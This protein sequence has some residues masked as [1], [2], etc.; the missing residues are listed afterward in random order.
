VSGGPARWARRTGGAV[1]G[2]ERS[3]SRPLAASSALRF[4]RSKVISMI[5]LRTGE[6]MRV[7]GAVVSEPSRILR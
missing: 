6:P 4:A 7:A 1:F 3:G 5:C 2:G